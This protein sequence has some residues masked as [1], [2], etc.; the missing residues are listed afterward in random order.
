MCITRRYTPCVSPDERGCKRC[1][2]DHRKCSFAKKKG[3]DLV[4]VKLEAVPD[5]PVPDSSPSPSRPQVSTHFRPF[6]DSVDVPDSLVSPLRVPGVIRPKRSADAIQ[7]VVDAEDRKRVRVRVE[8]P[9]D[10]SSPSVCDLKAEL[11]LLNIRQEKANEAVVSAV[12]LI[13]HLRSEA[14]SLSSQVS[15]LA[16]EIE[17]NE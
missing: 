4:S 1:A 3:A 7:D 15:V 11:T 10:V 12:S 16:G 14:A 17:D 2:R 8:S 6:A 9:S 5:L 13:R